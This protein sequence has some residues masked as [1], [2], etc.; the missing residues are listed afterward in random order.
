MTT[1]CVLGL[2][3]IGLP[4][5][6]MFALAGND[7]IGVDPSPRVQNALQAGLA[8]LEEPELQTLVT[9]AINSGRLK[10]RTR[11]EPADAFIIA[12]PTPLDAATCTADLSYVKEAARHIVPLLRRGSLVVLESTVPPGTTRD[13]LAPILGESGL[14]PGVDFH[15]AHCPER[16]LPGRILVELEQNDRL[17]GG[18]TPACAEEAAELYCSFVKG[19][20]MRTD[21][22]VAELVKVMENTYRDVNVALAN[23]FALISERIGVDVWEAI[24]LANHHPRVNVLTPGPGVG[25]H[26]IA[27]DPWFLIG[28]APDLAAL[29]RAARQVNDG[30]P[31]H[32]L[33]RLATMVA[34]PAPIAVLGVTYKAEVDDIRESPALRVAELAVERGYGVRLCDPH[35]RS[36]AP[37][38]PAPLLGLPQALRDAEAILLL[39]DHRAFH[40]LD[41][42]LAASLVSGKR[43]L[44]A[45]NVLDRPRW[46]SRGFEVGVLGAAPGG[47]RAPSGVNAREFSNL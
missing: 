25:G 28:A 12:V 31:F 27:V 20:I 45:R 4:T 34:P 29:I 22:T 15:V 5:G 38:L 14:E 46:Q 39:V 23:E 41:V 33:E 17:A 47:V 7:V 35:V 1:I 30:M 11:P 19:A 36:D 42:D 44:D 9:A 2:G 18:L 26:C 24:R 10:V 8:S 21:A 37:G 40:D 13:V 43:V 32:V 3:Y 6:S 16:V